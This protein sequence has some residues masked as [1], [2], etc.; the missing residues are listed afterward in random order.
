MQSQHKFTDIS[1]MKDA[2]MTSE[3]SDTDRI[4]IKSLEEKLSDLKDQNREL[5]QRVSFSMQ[6]LQLKDE[7][8]KQKDTQIEK[9]LV[10]KKQQQ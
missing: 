7:L 3:S 9:I 2:R 5:T 6:D 4:K 8:L 10:A 1:K